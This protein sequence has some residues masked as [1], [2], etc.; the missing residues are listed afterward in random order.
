MTITSTFHQGRFLDAKECIDNHLH[1]VN[2]DSEFV[3]FLCNAGELQEFELGL[4][5]GVIITPVN[6]SAELTL[7]FLE[8][9]AVAVFGTTFVLNEKQFNNAQC[10]AQFWHADE[11][12]E[13]PKYAL[14]PLKSTREF[15]DERGRSDR[16]QRFENLLAAKV[17]TDTQALEN[18]YSA[19]SAKC[20][21]FG[22]CPEDMLRSRLQA[23]LEMDWSNLSNAERAV[24][25]VMLDTIKH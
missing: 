14:V 19:F 21:K 4:D 9:E 24:I 6:S 3:G 18:Y 16:D 7:C 10:S 2:A 25:R 17:F 5:K 23:I 13:E 12:E 15:E 8:E 20:A 1:A 11:G 22:E